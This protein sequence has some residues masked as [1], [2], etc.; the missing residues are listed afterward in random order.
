MLREEDLGQIP[1]V[2]LHC[3]TS[4]SVP[5]MLFLPVTNRELVQWLA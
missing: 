4:V 3:P 2:A 1:G 5:S